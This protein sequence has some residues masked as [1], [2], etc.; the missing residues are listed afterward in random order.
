[1]QPSQLLKIPFLY[2]GLS[3]GGDPRRLG[4]WEPVL[5]RLKSRLAGWKSCFLSF[6]G[7]LVLLKYVLTFLPVYAL[8]F[9]KAPSAEEFN[10]ALLGKWCWRMLVDMEGL[11]FRVLAARYRVER[12]HLCAR[13]MRGSLWWRDIVRIRDGGGGIGGGWF[14]ECITK[15]VGDGVET[16]FW[17]DPW[18]V[19]NPLCERFGRLFDLAENK[20]ESV[21]EMFSLG[22]GA[23]GDAWVWRRSLRAWEEEMLRECQTLLLTVSLQDHSSDRWQ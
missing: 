23:D 2:L 11:W 14:G 1:M 10:L 3:I 16:F 17:T 9:F 4:F 15:K 21:A 6:G 22:W 8:F 7:R 18:V 5:A 13:G 20:S 19:G 12:G